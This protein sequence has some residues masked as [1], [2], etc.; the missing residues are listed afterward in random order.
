MQHHS[1]APEIDRKGTKRGREKS[2]WYVLF[3]KKTSIQEVY[4]P[5]PATIIHFSSL[6][7]SQGDPMNMLHHSIAPEIDRNGSEEGKRK[8]CL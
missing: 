2:A 5:T 6:R 1:L 7:E 8:E 4:L 3:Y